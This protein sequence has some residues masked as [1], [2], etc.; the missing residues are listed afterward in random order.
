MGI[1]VIVCGY[2]EWPGYAGSPA[3]KR[4][5]RANRRAILSLPASDPD[6]PFITRD[7]FSALP[8][9]ATRD[10]RIAQYENHVIH[11]AGDYKNM[12]RL[13]ADW[14]RKFE[15][16]LGRLCWYNAVATLDFCSYRYEWIVPFDHIDDRY[17]SDTPRPPTE[18]SF[19]CYHI[20]C[21][22]IPTDEAIDGPLD[23]LHHTPWREPG[24][25]S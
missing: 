5:Y 6:W 14:V 19:Q 20:D 17:Y 13:E 7:M 11:F 1:G 12:Y 15:A 25:P 4:I 23:S 21:Q 9:R 2:I 24:S 3:G 22:P 8:L 10:R 18:W 16:L